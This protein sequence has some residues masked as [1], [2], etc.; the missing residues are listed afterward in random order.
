MTATPAVDPSLDGA[1]AATT[2]PSAQY[3]RVHP[4]GRITFQVEL[5]SAHQVRLCPGGAP[6][7]GLGAG[8]MDLTRAEVGTWRLTVGPIPPGLY[9]YWLEVDGLA[10]N[11]PGSRCYFGH[12]HAV[13]AVE[14]PG[15]AAATGFYAL[16][17]VPHGQVRTRWHHTGGAG[18]HWRRSVIYTPA[19][20]DTELDRRYPVLYLQHGAGEDETGWVEQGRADLILDNLIAAGAALPMLV[21][22]TDGYARPELRRPAR[23][24]ART[25]MIVDEFEQLLRK[26]LVPMVDATYRTLPDREHRALA[27]LSMGARQSLDIGLNNLDTFA[28][29]GAFSPPPVEDVD[30]AT[31]FRG[32]LTDPA[33]L[34]RALRLLWVGCGTG[35]ARFVHWC[36]DLHRV[37]TD[38]GVAHETFSAPGTAHEWPTWR[39]CLHAFAQQVF[40]ARG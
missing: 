36:D 30:P 15:S 37:L 5:P 25:T 31:S 40:R 6:E 35:E 9:Y 11:D 18:D 28:W 8:P 24:P 14:V 39:A 21:V 29:V 12:G 17:D 22:M 26:D 1:R 19:G 13:S 10:V 16:T 20:Y 32:A 7:S 27:G 38:L 2:G 3:P 33:V 34:D 4:N 23:S